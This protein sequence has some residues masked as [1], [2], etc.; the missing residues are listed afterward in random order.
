MMTPPAVIAGQLADARRRGEPFEAVWPD[1]LAAG[2]AVAA[3]SRERRE[4][5]MVT[6]WRAA[7]ERQ[8]PSEP[9][10]ALRIVAEARA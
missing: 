2:V 10:L 7:F 8:V 1:A 9:E 3:D 5:E 4:W 6:T